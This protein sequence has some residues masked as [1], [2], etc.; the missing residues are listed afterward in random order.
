MSP[1]DA[2][3]LLLLRHR[4]APEASV[5]LEGEP[6]YNIKRWA[7]NAEKTAAA[8]ACPTN[9]GD[10]AE[11]LAFVQGRGVYKMQTRL[12]LAIKVCLPMPIKLD[13]YSDVIRREGA[14]VRLEHRVRA[15]VSLLTCNHI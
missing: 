7:E 15:A 6:G 4:L 9:A 14:I 8:V 2:R 10:V 13:S 3:S 5:N 11:L 12:D 1:I